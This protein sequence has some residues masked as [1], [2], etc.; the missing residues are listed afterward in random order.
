MSS[1]QNFLISTPVIRNGPKD[2]RRG[3]IHGENKQT[4]KQTVLEE[5]TQ[6]GYHMVS[7]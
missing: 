4:N 3:A 6:G 7:A 2:N 1:I 5:W